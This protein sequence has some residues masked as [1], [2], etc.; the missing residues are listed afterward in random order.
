[1]SWRSLTLFLMTH[2]LKNSILFLFLPVFS[3][4][5]L[6]SRKSDNYWREQERVS[7]RKWRLWN[8]GEAEV[9]VTLRQTYDKTS[10]QSLLSKR[11]GKVPVKT[12]LKIWPQRRFGNYVFFIF[13]FFYFHQIYFVRNPETCSFTFSLFLKDLN[14]TKQNKKRNK[15]FFISRLLMLV[16]VR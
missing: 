9:V 11:K 16:F 15:K 4:L 8:A 7:G 13:S 14:K 5:A 12:F 10:R 1:M 2:I 6:C 3:T